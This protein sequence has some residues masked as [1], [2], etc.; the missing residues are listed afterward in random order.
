MNVVQVDTDLGTM[1]FF[2]WCDAASW[3][4]VG[5]VRQASLHDAAAL[6]YAL[7]IPGLP[8]G[9]VVPAVN[10]VID[11]CLV[12]LIEEMRGA[13]AGHEVDVGQYR[14]PLRSI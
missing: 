8:R 5:R 1:G 9:S 6:D 14:I 11:I 3:V 4:I 10:I 2:Q 7:K 13:D 12:S